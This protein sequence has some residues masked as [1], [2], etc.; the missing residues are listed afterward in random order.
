MK[1]IVFNQTNLVNDGTNNT[2]VYRF[3]NSV[4]FTD[5]EIAV[6]SISMFYSWFNISSALG[7]NRFSF[8]W[9]QTA[10][11]NNYVT[12]T[13]TIPDGLYEIEDLNNYLQFVFQ[14]APSLPSQISPVPSNPFYLVNSSGDNV[15]FVEFVVNATAYA[16]QL[17]TYNVPATLPTG[18]TNPASTLL[19]LQSFN[20]VVSTPSGFS[21]IIGFSS[22]F[23]SAQNQNNGTP[24]PA[25]S[26]AYKIGSTFSYLS[27]TSPQVQPNSNLLLTLSNID[28]S[29]AS[30]NSIIYSLT[31]SVAIG[32]QISEKPPEFNWNRLLKG[33][34]NQLTLKFI[35]NDL[36]P[37]TIKD[38]N[39]TVM[40]AIRDLDKK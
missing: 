14:N 30:P 8:N 32:E 21:N 24:N 26:T 39:I 11:T 4:T 9:V 27:T 7:N 19:P 31:P 34:Y 1:T 35:G 10:G 38:P 25:T 3:P 16:V 2:M 15:F 37:V 5:A 23:S 18:W 33:T 17:N 20:P 22:T 40:M 6:V 13:V 12:Y 28:N 36:S 29:Y